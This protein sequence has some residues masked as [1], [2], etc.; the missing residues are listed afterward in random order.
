[1][2]D[3]LANLRIDLRRT[4]A[5]L[6]GEVA[7][8]EELAA[9]RVHQKAKWQGKVRAA[10]EALVAFHRIIKYVA[11]VVKEEEMPAG[12][13]VEALEGDTAKV[14]K[15]IKAELTIRENMLNARGYEAARW[16]ER[17]QEAGDCLAGWERIESAIGLSLPGDRL[18]RAAM[19]SG[20][21]V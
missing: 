15:L 21:F 10:R 4:L 1:M 12:Y 2:S 17:I 3:E 7:Y 9:V 8:R 11:A 19:Q 6:T 20:L 14:R 13:T 16:I 5:F 18:P